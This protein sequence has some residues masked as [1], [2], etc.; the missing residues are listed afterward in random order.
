[1]HERL[2]QRETVFT[3]RLLAVYRDEVALPDG[4]RRVRELVHHPGA[5][6]ILPI[7]R[8]GRIVLVEQYRHAV[9]RTLLEVPAGTREPGES[10]AGCAARELEEET[11]YRAGTLRELIRFAVSPGWTD[12]EL[13]VFVAE[14]LTR[15]SARPAEDERLTVHELTPEEAFAAI[16]RGEICDAK[17]LIALLG[18]FGWKLA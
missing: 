1:M 3:G 8:D 12:E 5:V 6:A 18:Y 14:E 4:Q 13:V 11:G 16:R 7:R 2:L 9:G 15:H 10:A 17:S